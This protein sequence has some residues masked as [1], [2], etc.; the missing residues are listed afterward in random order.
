MGKS[1]GTAI[2]AR[3]YLSFRLPETVA[4][5]SSANLILFQKY[6]ITDGPS[7]DEAFQWAKDIGWTSTWSLALQ[8]I[9]M[10][11]SSGTAILARPYLGLRLPQIGKGPFGAMW[12][13]LARLGWPMPDPSTFNVDRGTP[14]QLQE[15]SPKLAGNHLHEAWLRKLA[16]SAKVATL[17]HFSLRHRWEQS[18]GP[19]RCTKCLRFT[20]SM[21]LSH[22][23]SMTCCPGQSDSHIA[24]YIPDPGH[25]ISVHEASPIVVVSRTNCGSWTV[26][27]PIC[28]FKA[29]PGHMTPSG[30]KAL[31]CPDKGEH[32]HGHHLAEVLL[33][34]GRPL[35]ALS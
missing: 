12:L 6:K 21:L 15:T 9:G 7:L 4:T 1:S 30:K 31:V 8:G 2:L 35:P 18:S 3:P 19:Y 32:P 33:S 5:P 20:S 16:R 29:C 24:V 11:K 26:E 28:L 13:S 17:P 25:A 14:L 22:K 27:K 23:L 34:P 10:G